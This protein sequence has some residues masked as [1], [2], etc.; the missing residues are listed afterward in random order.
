MIF[1]DIYAENLQ[2]NKNINDLYLKIINKAVP[3]I[4]LNKTKS[5]ASTKAPSE[6]HNHQSKTIVLDDDDANINALRIDKLCFYL[7]YSGACLFIILIY[8]GVLSRLI[9]ISKNYINYYELD[10]TTAFNKTLIVII[11]IGVSSIL[12]L[13][14]YWLYNN[15][16]LMALVFALTGEFIS[17]AIIFYDRAG[18]AFA[19]PSFVILGL[20]L[21]Y[22]L[23]EHLMLYNR[24]FMVL[25]ITAIVVVIGE[26]IGGR[27]LIPFREYEDV[28]EP[29]TKKD[30]SY[31]SNR[32]NRIRFNSRNLEDN[33]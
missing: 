8:I 21:G 28:R 17:G 22:K 30:E 29:N 20:L 12:S 33:L 26:Q 31:Y 16:I 3:E 1:K 11:I 24:I 19:T 25:L 13:V 15:D 5:S 2:I 9:D 32:S 23:T 7:I 18:K 14:G 6:T 27:W 4:N 10:D